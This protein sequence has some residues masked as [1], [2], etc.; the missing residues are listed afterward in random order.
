MQV[1]KN[2][3]IIRSCSDSDKKTFTIDASYKFKHIILYA[4]AEMVRVQDFITYYFVTIYNHLL[5]IHTT[6]AS[7]WDK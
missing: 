2:Y 6:N 3:T 4:H 5:R 7:Q 1:K